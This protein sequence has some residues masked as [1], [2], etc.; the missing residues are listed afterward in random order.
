MHLIGWL[1]LPCWVLF[2]DLWSFF[3]LGHI[4]LF[5]LAYYIIRGRA[6]GICQGGQPTLLHCGA[7]C[8]GGVREGTMPLAQLSAC[9]QSLPPLLTSKLD[10]SSADSQV[11]GFVY[12]LGPCECSN[13][14]S[15]E[16]V[17]FSHCPN[18]HKCFQSQVLRLYFPALELWVVPSVLL[19]SCSSWFI[20]MRIWDCRVCQLLPCCNSSPIR[21]PS[22][23]LLPVWM[24]IS[25]LIPWLSD[26]H[27]VQISDSSVYLFFNL[28]LSFFWLC[29]EA[30]CIFLHL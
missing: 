23:S 16:T 4:C 18:P 28:L 29:K 2:W 11:G 26:F 13:G 10:L 1:S 5:Q 9:L 30:E 7:I 20:H 15:C 12:L 6:L 24:N 14:L 25:S 22:P 3:P 17:G 8:W 19:P 21:C 27:T